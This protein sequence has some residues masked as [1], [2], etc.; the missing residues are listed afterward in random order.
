MAYCSCMLCGLQ[1]TLVE[2]LEVIGRNVQGLPL[3]VFCSSRDVLDSVLAA[4]LSLPALA[5]LILVS[6]STQLRA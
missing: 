2:L 5:V 3:A 6:E 1:A 4:L